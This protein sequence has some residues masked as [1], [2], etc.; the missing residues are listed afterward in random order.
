MSISSRSLEPNE[1]KELELPKLSSLIEEKKFDEIR[2]IV[3]Q[4]DA[5]EDWDWKQKNKH[6]IEDAVRD[7]LLSGKVDIVTLFL[8]IPKA[9]NLA[10]EKFGNRKKNVLDS[11]IK[12]LLDYSIGIEFSDENNFMFDKKPDLLSYLKGIDVS[13]YNFIGVSI[14]GK[15]VTREMLIA[16]NLKG[17]DKAILTKNDLLDLK[18]DV[19]KQMLTKR[20]DDAVA[21]KGYLIDNNGIY[22]LVPLWSASRVGDIEAVKTRLAAQNNPNEAS[23]R[24]DS[25]IVTATYNRNFEVVKLLAAESLIDKQS[26][27]T[28]IAISMFY[29]DKTIGEYLSNT[30]QDVNTVDA[31]GNSQLHNVAKWGDLKEVRLL[32][33]KGAKVDIQNKNG[34]TPL[35]LAAAIKE[36]QGSDTVD[37]LLKHGADAKINSDGRSPLAQALGCGN[38][39]SIKLLMPY[40]EK[41]DTKEGEPWYLRFMFSVIRKPN[42]I[43]ILTL[44]K[45]AGADFNT[46]FDGDIL[47]HNVLRKIHEY[48]EQEQIKLINFFLNNGADLNLKDEA[49][50]TSLALL[51]KIHAEA[52]R[53]NSSNAKETIDANYNIIRGLL[54]AKMIPE[55]SNISELIKQRQ[56]LHDAISA[57]SVTD[58][59]TPAVSSP[60]RAGH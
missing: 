27:I 19:R 5:I 3:R 21:Q 52:S 50:L 1:L 42:A 60:K 11:L 28:A 4:F 2:A 17:A 13:G 22:N 14:A 54:L 47:F 20:L 24:G 56:N 32:I 41:N 10:Y 36:K 55:S 12:T 45:S 34:E 33:E 58:I 30:L 39:E 25:P 23:P 37:F 48:D 40:A 6:Y 57:A 29:S 46:P 43:E 26:I 49:G 8:S 38:T 59:S 15:P 51:Q 53:D 7:S 18:D 16:E 31:E 44:L 35:F 9:V